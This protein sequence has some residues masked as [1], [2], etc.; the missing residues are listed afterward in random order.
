MANEDAY[1]SLTDTAKLKKSQET[2]K[3]LKKSLIEDRR[4]EN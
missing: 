4:K 2:M 1:R 3:T